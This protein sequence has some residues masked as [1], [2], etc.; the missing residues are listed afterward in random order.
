MR[1]NRTRSLLPFLLAFVVLTVPLA[2]LWFRWGN[3]LYAQLLMELVGLSG[4]PGARSRGNAAAPRFI[5]V[6]P[7]VVLMWVTPGLGWRRRLFGSVFGLILLACVHLLLLFAVLEAGTG[8]QQ[9]ISRY[10]PFMVLADGTPLLL[11]LVF[12]RDFVR[13]AIPGLEEH[14]QGRGSA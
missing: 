4:G 8:G 13:S 2:Y 12:A 14:P 11:W 10:F 3:Q 7:F 9:N 6:V 1:E 5:S